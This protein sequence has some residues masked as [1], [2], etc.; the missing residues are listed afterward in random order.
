MTQSPVQEDQKSSMNRFATGY[1]STQSSRSTPP[2]VSAESFVRRETPQ[3]GVA[4]LVAELDNVQP[5]PVKDRKHQIEMFSIFKQAASTMVLI[6]KGVN[7]KHSQLAQLLKFVRA[8]LTVTPMGS[9]NS[10]KRDVAR[11][12]HAIAGD[13]PDTVWNLR[14]HKTLMVEIAKFLVKEK[15]EIALA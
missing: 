5:D 9:Y 12:E 8:A 4:F 14:E 3:N 7:P 1:T 2:V 15:E 11:L 10:L 13:E 6:L